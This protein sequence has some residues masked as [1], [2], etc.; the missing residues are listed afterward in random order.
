MRVALGWHHIVE[1]PDI[2]AASTVLALLVVLFAL[3]ASVAPAVL[4]T[5]CA[6]L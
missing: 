1:L 6:M 4:A 3:T 2:P 5:F